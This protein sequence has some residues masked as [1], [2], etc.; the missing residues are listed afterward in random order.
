MSRRNGPCIKCFE[1]WLQR[2]LHFFPV[3]YVLTTFIY[4]H[5]FFLFFLFFKKVVMQKIKRIKTECIFSLGVML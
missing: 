3:Y 1:I 2:I 5:C 4:K